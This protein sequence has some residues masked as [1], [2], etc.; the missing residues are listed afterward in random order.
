M[1]DLQLWFMLFLLDST[2]LHSKSW[3]SQP[4]WSM[5]ITPALGSQRQADLCKLRPAR[6][7]GG[8]RKQDEQRKLSV[9]LPEICARDEGWR[10]T[11]VMT[12][13]RETGKAPFQCQPGLHGKFHTSQR[14]IERFSLGNNS[15]NPGMIGEFSLVLT[16]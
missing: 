3:A 14:S 10:H 1:C 7:A 12:A 16:S 4:W 15:S 11:P 6:T 5:L 8:D 9:S 2:G 13:L